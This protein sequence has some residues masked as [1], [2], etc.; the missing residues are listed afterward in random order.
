MKHG[1]FI[2]GL[3]G[4]LLAAGGRLPAA[5]EMASTVGLT[6]QVA[7]KTWAYV[8]W[9]PTGG[10]NDPAFGQVAVY[11]KSGRLDSTAPFTR[12]SVTSRQSDPAII[13]TCLRRGELLGDNAAG[14]A[15]VL[16]SGFRDLLDGAGGLT[17]ADK[18]AVTLLGVDPSS[19]D[20]RFL[21]V[22]ARRHPALAMALGQAYAGELGDHV[23]TFEI[24][25]FNQT[26][27]TDGAVI[28]RVELDPATP[29]PLPAPG[30]AVGV[31][32]A[33]PKG[34]LN[35]RLR[36]AT[37]D[38]LRD[39][40]LLQFGF[41][42]FRV[43]K[44]RAESRGWTINSPETSE[45]L[46]ACADDPENV[47]KVNR[48]P[49]LPDVDLND[50]E[51][52]HPDDSETFFA[53]DDNNRYK[54]GGTK[55]A[56]G[57]EYY[58]Y[59]AA[60]DLL[61]RNGLL[62]PPS[63]IKI[64]SRMPP[65][66]P[67]DV[68]VENAIAFDGGLRDHHLRVSWLAPEND[69]G[70]AIAAYYIYRWANIDDISRFGRLK[71]PTQGLPHVNLI[72]VLPA[73]DP[74]VRQEFLDNL[75]VDPP[76]W[77]D[78]Q[79]PLPHMA[80]N[81]GRTFYYTVRAMDAASC[82]GNLSG[83]SAPGW[84]V[85]R[86]NT[87]PRDPTEG[88]VSTTNYLPSVLHESTGT[89]ADANARPGEILVRLVATATSKELAWADFYEREQSGTA[90]WLGRGRFSGNPPNRVAVLP[91]RRAKPGENN[92][93]YSCEV[94]T[95]AGKV[96][97]RAE[98]PNS[99]GLPSAGLGYDV[100]FLATVSKSVTSQTTHNPRDP[101]TG[102][103]N[104]VLGSLTMPE[105]A[106]QW[107]LYLRVDAGSLIL[108]GQGVIQNGV[109]TVAW[110]DAAPPASYARLCYY[111]QAFDAHGNPG[112][113]F[114]IACITSG[115][116]QNLPVPML[117][118]PVGRGNQ[119]S[120]EMTLRWFSPPAGVERFEVWIATS[121]GSPP[122]TESGTKLSRD[123]AVH[124]NRLPDH[125]DLDFAVFDT[126]QVR[127]LSP[128]GESEFTCDV[129]VELNQNYTVLVRAVGPGA[130]DQRIAGGFGKAESFSWLAQQDSNREDVPWPARP[131]PPVASGFHSGIGLR[132]ITPAD[133]SKLD[134]SGV[135]VRV[136]RATD[137]FNTDPVYF[138]DP[139]PIA[140]FLINTHTDPLGYI[141]RNEQTAANEV[142]AEAPG[143]L[144]PMMLYRMQVPN[145]NFPSVSGDVVQVSPLMEKIAYEE[146][147]LSGRDTVVIWD[148]YCAL[149]PPGPIPASDEKRDL[150]V[151]DRHPVL[152]GAKYRYLVV[153]F[154]PDH[155]IERV[156]PAGEIEIP[157]PP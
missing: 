35:V 119:F 49:I 10:A 102:E 97:A 116:G 61:G 73:G 90:V 83:N 25:R 22:L 43:T 110:T 65:L 99:I 6:A 70:V 126:A 81:Q 82:G 12:V 7:G 149:L 18:I 26:T 56:D 129:P 38:A 107:R 32:D 15:D 152:A 23:A 95:G 62:S 59:V 36:W 115:S 63:S 37:P 30:A 94:G 1:K 11:R 143:S 145:A 33:S 108:V 93:L 19:D 118:P 136:G 8:L 52:L 86:D 144:F 58:Y 64:C 5:E 77:A 109:R 125:P 139:I 121:P 28:G 133:S 142:Q 103:I 31:S 47:R 67:R 137:T 155:E 112:R 154:G 141:F 87:G 134:W 50:V 46:A 156:I 101:D 75:M 40:S 147:Q 29:L 71:H 2:I 53:I 42:V 20:W 128:N 80:A 105:D 48:K 3:L 85:L 88:T 92:L 74:L 98:M 21:L 69:T 100:R 55:F 140:G 148:R 146:R 111:G 127:A 96:S 54:P 84:G 135:G 78:V 120:P 13:A 27:S 150:F 60:R 51:A 106:A 89:M 157:A 104:P 45:M 114:L 9:Q 123:L 132:F 76:A 117:A 124:P 131:L 151:V 138:Q 72:A 66:P 57:E 41:D 44:A 24:R 17:L 68:R 39:L 122:M 79:T 153:R 91:H 113:L 130:A 4:A 34:D 14:L 16:D